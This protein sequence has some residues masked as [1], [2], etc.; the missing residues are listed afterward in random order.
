MQPERATLWLK[1]TV[2]RRWSITAGG[3]QQSV[4]SD[5]EGKVDA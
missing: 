1:L 5:Q 4:I 2:D 3:D